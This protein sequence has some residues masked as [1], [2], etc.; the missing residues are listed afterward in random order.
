MHMNKMNRLYNYIKHHLKYCSVDSG[1]GGCHGN[2]FVKEYFA[3]ISS[4]REEWPFSRSNRI[5]IGFFNSK[6]RSAP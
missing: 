2:A 4:L 1:Q 3:K 6:S 5:H